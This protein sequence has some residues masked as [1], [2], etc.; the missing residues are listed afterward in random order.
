MTTKLQAVR[1][2]IIAAVPS[3]M[4]L[5]L[6]CEVKF[7][8]ARFIFISDGMAGLYTIFNPKS[9]AI[10]ANPKEVEI[11]GRKIGLA[12]VLLA[13]E[14]KALKDLEERSILPLP[15]AS[16]FGRIADRWDLK[17]DDLSLADDRMIHML[18]DLLV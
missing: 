15:R 4:E 1:E 5:V 14:R 7:R 3:I 17:K 9:H 16:M 12:D 13:V 11:L 18:Y 6:G 8:D 10:H 2:K